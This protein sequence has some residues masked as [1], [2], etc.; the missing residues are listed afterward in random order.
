[1]TSL[2]ENAKAL[3]AKNQVLTDK[4]KTL[5]GQAKT[6]SEKIDE[7]ESKLEASENTIK[8]LK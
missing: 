2:R 8:D 3:T 6:K 5:L 7:L 4:I 1:V